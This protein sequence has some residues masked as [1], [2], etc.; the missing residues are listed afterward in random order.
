MKIIKTGLKIANN[1]IRNN[2]KMVETTYWLWLAYGMSMVLNWIN[3]NKPVQYLQ[4][5]IRILL[6]SHTPKLHIW[7]LE[8]SIIFM[9]VFSDVQMKIIKSSCKYNDIRI[10]L[11]M[12]E[13]TYWHWLHGMSMVLNWIHVINLYIISNTISILFGSHTKSC[14]LDLWSI[15]YNFHWK[16]FG[17]TQ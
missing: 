10:N 2:R 17:C 5:S 3:V 16:P 9:K 8:H 14:A 15:F 6:R 11:K 13:T 1:N 4:F 12:V 7:F